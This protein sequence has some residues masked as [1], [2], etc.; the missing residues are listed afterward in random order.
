MRLKKSTLLLL[1][2]LLLIS[3][4]P[5]KLVWSQ[6]LQGGLLHSMIDPP[7]HFSADQMESTRESDRPTRVQSTNREERPN[8]YIV[9]IPNEMD[10][11]F[12]NNPIHSSTYGQFGPENHG[13][14]VFQQ[15]DESSFQIPR[16]QQRPNRLLERFNARLEGVNMPSTLSAMDSSFGNNFDTLNQLS[17]GPQFEADSGEPILEFAPPRNASIK[18]DAPSVPIP[19]ITAVE[20]VEEE[21]EAPAIVPPVLPIAKKSVAQETVT[22]ATVAKKVVAAKTE[23]VQKTGPQPEFSVTKAD[24]DTVTLE[25]SIQQTVQQQTAP[26]AALAPATPIVQ[27]TAGSDRVAT[28]V[29]N[30]KIH[31]PMVQPFNKNQFSFVVENVGDSQARD[32]VVG[33]TVPEWS[34]IS[35]VLPRSALMTQRHTIITFPEVAAGE[36]K[37]IHVTATSTTAQ[38]VSFDATLTTKTVQKFSPMGKAV[39]NQP[40]QQMAQASSVQQ[41]T[42]PQQNVSNPVAPNPFSLA[43]TAPIATQQTPMPRAPFQQ[44]P[45]AQAQAA[46]SPK[47]TLPHAMTA[48][49]GLPAV[50][51]N[52]PAT[53]ATTQKNPTPRDQQGTG[54]GR[55]QNP[56]FDQMRQQVANYTMPYPIQKTS[57]EPPTPGPANSVAQETAPAFPPSYVNP[58]MPINTQATNPATSA[59]ATANTAVNATTQATLP[60]Q[61]AGGNY[62]VAAIITGPKVLKHN[63][64]ANY[65]ISIY[66]RT[67]QAAANLQMQL[68]VPAGLQ[69]VAAEPNAFYD[70][71]MRQVSWNLA[72]ISDRERIVLRYRVQATG[73]LLQNQKAT[74]HIG[75]QTIGDTYFATKIIGGEQPI[76]VNQNNNTVRSAEVNDNLPLANKH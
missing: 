2:T 22:K 8:T 15:S 33:I 5:A 45:F 61:Q 62:V 72:G 64:I 42:Q 71:Q 59:Q 55:V 28:G 66:N 3:L 50:P 54:T 44:A 27:Q 16:N 25:T 46:A 39:S 35:A 57:V 68:A 1:S 53:T 74:L 13:Q 24:A 31:P 21:P 7:K 6:D 40:A 49:S 73:K 38:P 19:Q 12:S 20:P 26:D 9:E 75:Q 36:Q 11:E 30:V 17:L 67:G 58:P 56:F 76:A 60:A 43:P 34:V 51:T 52:W 63:E 70:E 65:E 29:S 69:V 10:R 4:C 32:V 41:P 48:T 23:T 14:L 47:M 18:S 37:L